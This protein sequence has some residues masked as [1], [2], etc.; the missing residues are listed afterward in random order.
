MR[1]PGSTECVG[2]RADGQHSSTDAHGTSSP[3][4]HGL[5]CSTISIGCEPAAPLE[6]GAGAGAY[7]HSG[8]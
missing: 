5:R 7:L 6:S 4:H 2:A 1:L 3:W 8:C